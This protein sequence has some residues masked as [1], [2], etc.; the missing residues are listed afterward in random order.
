MFDLQP[1]LEQ[2]IA[3]YPIHFLEK[4]PLC[5]LSVSFLFDA[6][7]ILQNHFKSKLLGK[8]LHAFEMC[9]NEYVDF[10]LYILLSIIEFV[11]LIEV[12]LY[13]M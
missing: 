7:K 12:H 6:F 3:K 11:S 2:V 8:M 9:L 13:R 10:Y 1:W 4:S 5:D